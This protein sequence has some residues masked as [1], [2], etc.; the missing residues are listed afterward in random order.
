MSAT[1]T[2]ATVVRRLEN[3]AAAYAD[4]DDTL[5]LT[6]DRAAVRDIAALRGRVTVTKAGRRRRLVGAAPLVTGN[7]KLDKGEIPTVG[8][9]HLPADRVHAWASL[10]LQQADDDDRAFWEDAVAATARLTLCPWSTGSCRAICLASSGHYGLGA[11]SGTGLGEQI[12]AQGWRTALLLT[13]PLSWVAASCRELRLAAR[14]VKRAGGSVL[15]F[16]PSVLDDIL[17][18]EQLLTLWRDIVAREGVDLHVYRYTKAP[19]RL[20]S[21]RSEHVTLSWHEGRRGTPVT[22][23]RRTGRGVAT[24]CMPG[25]TF[26]G[27]P[28][29]DGDATDYRPGD[30][31]GP[32]GAIV[33]LS[34]KQVTDGRS[35][36]PMV[37]AARAAGFIVG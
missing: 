6:F 2:Y 22:L 18:P 26:T 14:R 30:V 35:M 5:R 1:L 15:A 19:D 28:V 27:V 9:A 10:Q 11:G 17:H 24:V 23:A 12:G 25:V 34:V 33:R 21:T 4:A 8:I 7:T 36:A 3:A 20:V 13:M 29:I 16:R 32:E 31:I 37:T